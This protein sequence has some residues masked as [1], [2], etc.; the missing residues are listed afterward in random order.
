MPAAMISILSRWYFSYGLH[1][2]PRGNLFVA[3]A[4]IAVSLAVWLTFGS[5][6]VWMDG[7]GWPLTIPR[8]ATPNNGGQVAPES[9]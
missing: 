1:L 3:C 7:N 4:S 2:P 9:F 6:W 8:A 5:F